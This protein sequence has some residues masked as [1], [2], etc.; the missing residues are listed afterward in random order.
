MTLELTVPSIS[1]FMTALA[2]LI[3][4][5]IM[6]V[7]ERR[8]SNHSML[9]GGVIGIFIAVLTGHLIHN[10]VLHLT[11]PIFTI[12]VSYTLFQIGSIGGADLKALIILSIISPGIELALWVEPVFEA[13]IGGGLEILIML[14]FGYAYSK[15]TRKEN[16]LPQDERRITP[17]IPF[18][19]LAYVLIQMMAIF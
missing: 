3:I 6:D 14:T 7:R 2:I 11:A 19:C 13:I 12:V 18:L 17:L 16:G 4:F 15:W 8:V 9:I 1:T 5:S 10:L